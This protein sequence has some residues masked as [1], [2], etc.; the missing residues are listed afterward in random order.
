MDMVAGQAGSSLSVE[1]TGRRCVQDSGRPAPV[2]QASA[3]SP[4]TSSTVRVSFQ[5]GAGEVASRGEKEGTASG[6]YS[7]RAS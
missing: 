7:A 6:C 3:P 4:D 2:L 1:N 5:H